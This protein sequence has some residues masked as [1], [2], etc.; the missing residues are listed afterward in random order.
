MLQWKNGDTGEELK[1]IKEGKKEKTVNLK[2][3]LLQLP[4]F[5]TKTAAPPFEKTKASFSLCST[6]TPLLNYS[7]FSKASPDP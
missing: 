7:P 6:K 1:K 5:E 4:P 3:F 2:P